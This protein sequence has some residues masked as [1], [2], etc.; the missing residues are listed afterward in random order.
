MFSRFTGRM[1]L[2]AHRAGHLMLLLEFVAC[3]AIGTIQFEAVQ[4]RDR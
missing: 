3:A 4:D 1:T 2:F